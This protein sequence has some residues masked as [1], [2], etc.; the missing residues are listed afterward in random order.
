VPLPASLRAVLAAIT[1]T[2]PDQ[3][4]WLQFLKVCVSFVSLLAAGVTLYLFWFPAREP[5][6]VTTRDKSPV[7]QDTKGDITIQYGSESEPAPSTT[8]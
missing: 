2:E 7:I 3:I 8:R 1:R 4:G 6:T 5:G